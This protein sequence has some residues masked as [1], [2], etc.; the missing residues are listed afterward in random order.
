MTAS[1][2]VFYL[3]ATFIL[4]TAL[5]AV[6]TLK[7]FRA[8]IFLLFS[9]MG[10]AA[11]YFWMQVEFV[12]AVQI[13]VYVG[14]IVVL[15]LF[16]I[17]LTQ[18]A[19]SEMPKPGLTRTV[20]SGFA[21]LFGFGLT[22]LLIDQNGFQATGKEFEWNMGIIGSQLLNTGANGYALPFEVISILLLASMVGC[23]VIA[24][25]SKP[26]MENEKMMES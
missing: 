16:S 22:Y 9:L 6:T 20:A 4:G 12:A 15:I 7:V 26:K 13:V 2:I 8:A 25:K 11:L 23:I 21:A 19:G 14:G 18:H 3:I 17:F 24:M 5:L 10:I 1:Q